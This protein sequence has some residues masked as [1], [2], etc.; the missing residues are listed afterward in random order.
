MSIPKDWSECCYYSLVLLSNVLMFSGFIW[1]LIC[2]AI[3]LPGMETLSP[4]RWL[5]SPV[6]IYPPCLTVI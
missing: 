5:I 6:L 4:G 1:R 2:R 3:V